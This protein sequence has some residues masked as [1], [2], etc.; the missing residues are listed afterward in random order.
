ML[1]VVLAGDTK[2]R[3]VPAFVSPSSSFVLNAAILLVRWVVKG[4]SVFLF[5]Y[6]LLNNQYC[7]A[8]KAALG[9]NPWSLSS[10]KMW[11][12]CAVLPLPYCGELFLNEMSIPIIE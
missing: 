1:A 3:S 12:N 8:G 5:P 10:K 4:I 6:F 11:N 7:L 2:G 9:R